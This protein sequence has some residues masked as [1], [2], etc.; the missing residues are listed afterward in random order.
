MNTFIIICS[1]ILLTYLY[2]QTVR[3]LRAQEEEAR[4]GGRYYEPEPEQEP[5]RPR[6]DRQK[7]EL[8]ARNCLSCSGVKFDTW[9]YCRSKT[10]IELMD[11]IRDFNIKI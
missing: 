7:L 8:I 11:I 10:D 1:V 9:A 2:I 6:M 4:T 5:E 3:T